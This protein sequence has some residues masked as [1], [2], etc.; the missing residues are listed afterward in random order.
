MSGQ[1]FVYGAAVL[2]AASVFNRCIGFIYQILMIRLIKP[3]GVGLFSMVFPVYV[4][5]FVL[6]TMGIPVAISKLVAE[7]VAVNNLPG[8]YRTFKISLAIISAVSLFF[9]LLLLAGSPLLVK[10]LFPNPDVYL[11]FISLVP[12]VFIVSLCSAFRGFFQG[13]QRMSPTAVTQ[14]VEQLVRVTA[15]LSIAWI[16]LPRGVIYASVGISLG[17]VCGELVGFIFMVYIYITRRPRIPVPSFPAE[18][19]AG[20]LGRIFNLGI[21]VTLTRFV[22]TALMSLDALLIPRRLQL[23]GMSLGDATATY[24]Q[25]VGIAETLL[26]SPGMVTI[27]LAT[28]LVPAVSDA[29]AQGRIYLVRSRIEEAIRIT[30][31]VGSPV[32]AIFLVMPHDLCQVLFGYGSAGDSL[33][34][35]ALSG[36]FLYLQQTTTGILQGL[37]KAGIPFKNLLLAS[38]IK[39]LG[40]Y[41]LTAVPGFS[42]RGTAL[43]MGTSYIIMSLL[44]YRDLKKI[45]GLKIN[46]T[47]CI[48]KPIF[49]SAAAAFA[50]LQLKP[51]LASSFAPGL[52]SLSLNLL[53]GSFFYFFVLYVI[54]GIDTSDIKRIR[55]LIKKLGP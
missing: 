24:G 48:Y 36:P 31:M 9:T 54:G 27:A 37:G 34:I 28:A 45:T 16:L 41:Y 5:V 12:G 7:E 44:N 29:L 10:H 20:T 50:M 19:L 17:L 14:V 8:A 13:L 1:S 25:F 26:F 21:P 53:F 32:A 2:L 18:P 47:L 52:L 11:C 3:E 33:L 30:V 49:A 6:A 43:S 46:C 42:I 35:M 55:L 15:G 38:V 39:I 22:S 40:I 23:A 4:M 51:L